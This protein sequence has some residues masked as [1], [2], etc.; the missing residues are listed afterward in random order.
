MQKTHE[1][2]ISIAIGPEG[3]WIDYEVEQFTKAGF[4]A[5]T[6]GERILRVDTAVPAII[7]QI[8]SYL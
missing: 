1:K 3:G 4:S 2:N 7:S 8:A 6:I 5:A